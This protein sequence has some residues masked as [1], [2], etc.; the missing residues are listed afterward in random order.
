MLKILSALSPEL[1]R[2]D[3]KYV[4]EAKPGMIYNTVSGETFD[5]QEGVLVVPVGYRREYIEWRPKDQGGGIVGF[6]D[7]SSET[8]R[9]AVK[10]DKG[11]EICENGNELQNTAQHFVLVLRE[12]GGWDQAVISM[13]STQLKKS[14]KWNSMMLGLKLKRADGSLFTPASYSHQYHLTT[15]PES[16][17]QGNWDGWAIANVG[18]IS[19]PELYAAS[20]AF[21]ASVSQGAVKAKH[22]EDEQTVVGK[23]DIP[24]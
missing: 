8:V 19:D 12:D 23:E 17:D 9:K 6:H 15:V 1:N 20:K 10:G 4:P 11:K 7:A 18:P 16:N 21:A 3:G 13:K 2:H 22:D 24:F 5:G 14:R